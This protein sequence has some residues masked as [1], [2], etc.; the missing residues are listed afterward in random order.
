M[1]ARILAVIALALCLACAAGSRSAERP[2]AAAAGVAAT[3]LPRPTGSYDSLLARLRAG[4]VGIDFLSLRL[5]YA[6]TP[7]YAPYDFDTESRR[8][9]FAAATA[10][11]HQKALA[12]ADSIL[13]TNY[14]DIEAH[15]VSAESR[16]HLG[17]SAKAAYHG[18]IVRGLI[19][20][21]SD[22][23][24]GQSP[25]SAIVVINIR[26]EYALL[27]A[28]GLERE[29]QALTTCGGHPCDM[30]TAVDRRSG[31]TR[32]LYFN[33]GIAYGSFQ[34]RLDKDSIAQKP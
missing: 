32:T 33:V 29:T 22:Y 18:A 7:H 30:L 23:A 16:Q 9:M 3:R 13:A 19:E 4:D 28:L 21:M 11:N 5:A 26:E 2:S 31:K 14:V 12:L 15:L 1:S 27:A 6:E 34:R 17:D 24:S 25:D 8:A 20:S 10:G